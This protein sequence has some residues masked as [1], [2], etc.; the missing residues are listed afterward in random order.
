MPGKQ[1][2][3]YEHA[4]W[5][6][7]PLLEAQFSMMTKTLAKVAVPLVTHASSILEVGP[8]P[9]TWTKILLAANPTAR[10]VLLDIS[11]EMLDRARHTLA[12]HQGITY[13]EED[14]A[15]YT[16]E[17]KHDFFFSSRALEYMP[18]KQKAV[19][20]VANALAPG[21]EGVIITKMPKE[22][23]YKLRGRVVP[24]FHRG[25]IAPHALAKCLRANGLEVRGVR[26]ATATVPGMRSAWLNQLVHRLLLSIPLVPLVAVFAESYA[27][28]FEKP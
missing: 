18:D 5:H 7:A 16:T 28:S 19:S 4:R 13:I 15:N 12:A 14:L 11:R 6:A 9:G 20:V 25:Q 21:G 24:E 26:I 17:E 1:G 22:L 3:D 8:G 27:I 23:F 2:Q 10:Y